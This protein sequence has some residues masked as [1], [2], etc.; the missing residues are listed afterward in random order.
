MCSGTRVIRRPPGVWNLF[1]CFS[2]NYQQ[3]HTRHTLCRMKLE[4]HMDRDNC[5]NIIIPYSVLAIIITFD[6]LFKIL[7]FTFCVCVH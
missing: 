7:I 1:F 5:N 6:T 4:N 2:M 3:K